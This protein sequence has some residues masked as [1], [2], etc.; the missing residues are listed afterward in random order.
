[1]RDPDPDE[2]NLAGTNVGDGVVV[3]TF[4]DSGGGLP[5]PTFTL[6]YD[7]DPGREG[8][9]RLTGG[10]SSQPLLLDADGELFGIGPHFGAFDASEDGDPDT[11]TDFSFSTYA[12]AY[13][14][15]LQAAIDADNQ[16]NGTDYAI[17]FRVFE[18]PEPTL[19]LLALA[20][21]LLI[22]RRR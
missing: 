14:D 17:D 22:R 19:G 11:N 2:L 13:R 8:E 6:A 18:V 10:D 5:R 9:V 16:A 3:A 20:P 1:M 15:Q 7:F 21:A 12:G 4:D